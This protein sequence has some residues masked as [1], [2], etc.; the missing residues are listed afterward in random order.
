[1]CSIEEAWA[2]QLFENKP[3]QSQG[4]IHRK[5]M[6]IPNDLFQR[7]DQFSIG[8]KEPTA[9]NTSQGMNSRIP[10]EPRVPP[11]MV[12]ND[13][14][15]INLASVPNNSSMY[16]GLEPRP[17]YM[18]IYDNAADYLAP[19]NSNRDNFNDINNAFTVSDTVN[20]FM[21]VDSQPK[22]ETHMDKHMDKHMGKMIEKMSDLGE[23]AVP[24][25]NSTVAPNEIHLT[26]QSIMNR[27]DQLEQDMRNCKSRN[28][29]D[30]ILYILVGMLIAFII[31]SII[32]QK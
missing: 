10:R 19:M 24:S 2:G 16:G 21:N 26:L 11:H 32:R 20:K 3:V 18:S 12:S 15:D 22:Q 4:D 13:M 6:D 29:H 23:V 17:A 1:M 28:M 8:R 31:Y 5:Y 9:R 27:L 7:N 25:P 30:M 14:M